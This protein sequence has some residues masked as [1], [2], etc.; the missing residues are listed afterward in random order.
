VKENNHWNTEIFIWLERSSIGEAVRTTSY[1]YPILESL[2]ILGIALL[3]GS[4]VAFDLRLLGI[5]KHVLPVTTAAR[6]LLPLSHIGFTV[7]AVTGMALF[8]AS[9]LTVGF[10]VAAP[11]KLGLIFISGVNLAVFHHGVYRTVDNWD[12]QTQTPV[13]ARLAAIISTLTWTGVIIAG[14]LLAYE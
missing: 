9:A 4:A 2:H 7:A 12:F 6:H 14:R 5:G 13:R 10:S 8:A 11:W 3:V 1:L